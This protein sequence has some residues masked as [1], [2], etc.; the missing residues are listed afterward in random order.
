M[1]K[2]VL[3]TNMFL[4]GF[5]F[6]GMLKIVFDLVLD[7][8]LQMY[9]SSALTKEIIKKLQRFEASEQMQ[10][11]LLLF[12]S[13]RGILI[14][15]KVKVTICR[16]PEDNFLLELAEAAGA[17]YLITRDKDLLDLKDQSWKET[18]IVKPEVFIPILRDKKL[19]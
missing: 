11:E 17:N 19:L 15:P 3:D 9:V 1:L 10:H 18:K 2:V 8:K 6:H 13:N 5:L 16:D 14:N 4:S 12:I 7:N